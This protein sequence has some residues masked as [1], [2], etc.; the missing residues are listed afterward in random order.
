MDRPNYFIVPAVV[1]YDPQ[2]RPSDHTVWATVHYFYK[3]LGA[4]TA[5]NGTLAEVAKCSEKAVAHAIARLVHRQ[6]LGRSW[7]GKRRYLVPRLDIFDQE[8]F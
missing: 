8:K 5:S 7:K 6:H 1:A 4:C 3:T 2:L